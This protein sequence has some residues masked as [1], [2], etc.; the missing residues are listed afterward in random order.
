[1][2]STATKRRDSRTRPSSPLRPIPFFFL[3]IGNAAIRSLVIDGTRFRLAHEEARDRHH[4]LR[5]SLWGLSNAARG[6]RL[7]G[8][9]RGWGGAGLSRRYVNRQSR[10][11]ATFMREVFRSNYCPLPS[12]RLVGANAASQSSQIPDC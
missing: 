10:S 9:E 7:H 8:F 4:Y 5:A 11:L 1:M 12:Q 6:E 2:R 3:L